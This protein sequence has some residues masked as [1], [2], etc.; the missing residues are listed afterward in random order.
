MKAKEEERTEVEREKK[1]ARGRDSLLAGSRCFLLP[2][3]PHPPPPPP[4][5][6]HLPTYQ[7]LLHPNPEAHLK[8]PTLP[9][10]PA[11]SPTVPRENAVPL[12]SVDDLSGFACRKSQRTSI[13]S[14]PRRFP[15]PG[16]RA[17]IERNR[18]GLRKST[19]SFVLVSSRFT[20]RP[21]T[22]SLSLSRS[23]LG[24]RN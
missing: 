11:H 20:D 8:D 17:G 18:K 5:L 15:V 1:R 16:W 2:S 9:P 10:S 24:Q 6:T 14:E 4:A 23:L 7:S 21:S 3:I 19:H 12:P 13:Q 22:F